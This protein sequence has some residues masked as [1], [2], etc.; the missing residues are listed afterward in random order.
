MPRLGNM[1]TEM[2]LAACDDIVILTVKDAPRTM[3]NIRY[4]LNRRGYFGEVRLAR[5]D[6]QIV[7]KKNQHIIDYIKKT[8]MESLYA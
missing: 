4:C 6:N 3:R 8:I 7:A 5:I 1:Y 2:I